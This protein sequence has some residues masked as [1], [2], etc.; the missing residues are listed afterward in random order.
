MKSITLPSGE[1]ESYEYDKNG[2]TT[3]I[4]DKSGAKTELR[5]DKLDRVIEAINPLGYMK[6]FSYDAAGRLTELEQYRLIE[7]ATGSLIPE[8]Q[9][10][11]YTRNKKD[12]VVAVTSPLDT[13]VKFSYNGIGQVIAKLDEEGNETLYEYNESNDAG[14]MK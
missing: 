9:I 10:T 8:P 3:S 1:S 14:I 4:T 5:Y 11:T 7:D 12:E 6:K 13:I 2:N